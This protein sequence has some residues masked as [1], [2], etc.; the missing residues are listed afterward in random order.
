LKQT[1]A[2]IVGIVIGAGLMFSTGAFA[3]TVEQVKAIFFDYNIYVN[4]EKAEL[5]ARPLVY[6]GTTYLPVREVANLVGYDVTY[7]SESATISLDTVVEEQTSSKSTTAVVKSTDDNASAET[8]QVPEGFISIRD[9]NT[10]YSVTI[11]TSS[12]GSFVT[13]LDDRRNQDFPVTSLK[14]SGKIVVVNGV[15]YIS[16]AFIKANF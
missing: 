12:S 11:V 10:K 15:T 1:R 4:G 8:S 2:L 14:S 16:E 3:A 6:N 5:Q 9:A 13:T 7:E